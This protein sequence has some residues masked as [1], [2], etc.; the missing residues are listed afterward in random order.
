MAPKA[1]PKAKAHA[2]PAGVRRRPAALAVAPPAPGRRRGA[3]RRPAAAEEAEDPWSAGQEVDLHR[4]PLGQLRPGLSLVATQRDYFG[5]PT[6]VAG[7]IARVQVERDAVY[8]YLDL[9]GTDSENV[10]RAHTGDKTQQFKLHL[11][12]PGCSQIESGDFLVHALR[13]RQTKAEG[14]EGWVRALA[15]PREGGEDDLAKL[16]EREQELLRERR[17][18]EDVA[19]GG[20]LEVRQQ[21]EE[22]DHKKSKKDKKKKKDKTEELVS[23][24]K[25]GKAVQKDLSL[26][27]AGTGLD[28]REKVRKRVLRRARKLASRKKRRSSSSSSPDSSETSSSTGSAGAGQDGVFSEETK[29][30]VIAERYPGALGLETLLSMRRSLLTTAGEESDQKDTSPIALLYFRNVLAKKASGPQARE[31]LTLATTIDT[32]LRGKTALAVDI[33]CQRL[34]A[35]EATLAGTH[36]AVAQKV[37]LASGEATA[38]LAR[39][40]LQSAQKESYLDAR[41]KWQS[42]SSGIKGAPKGKTKGKDHQG[43]DD[44]KDENRR[45]KGKGGEKKG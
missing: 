18:R 5:A 35:Q 41:A 12:S 7:T 36:W 13:G 4:I 10:L 27:Y 15:P 21:A 1:K 45:D 6:K 30:K 19:P 43:K 3:L 28:P 20:D 32:L 2:R 23:G 17:P 16:R 34:K 31:L 40:E 14:E 11:C 25:A 44:R 29:T 37:E 9:T 33:L 42:Q 24:R 26:L 38:L 39:G 22:R 8:V